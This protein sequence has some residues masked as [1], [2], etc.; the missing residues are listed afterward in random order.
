[1]QWILESPTLMGYSA[2]TD[3]L[4]KIY[5]TTIELDGRGYMVDSIEQFEILRPHGTHQDYIVIAKVMLG[6]I[7]GPFMKYNAELEIEADANARRN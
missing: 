6:R 1:M 4:Q 2:I 3:W 5:H 7:E